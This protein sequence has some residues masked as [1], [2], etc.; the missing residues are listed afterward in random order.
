MGVSET[1]AIV[2][3]TYKLAEADKITVFLS[4][5]SGVMRGVARGARRLKSKFG[6]ALEPFTLISLSYFEKEGQ[7]LVAIRQ[8]EILRSYFE[9]SKNTEIVVALEYIGG[10]ILEFTPPHEPNEKIFR[11]IRAC[12]EAIATAPENIRHVTRYCEVW[13]LKLAGFLPDLR[14]C[15]NCKKPL[16]E[17]REK[18]YLGTDGALRCDKCAYKLDLLISYEAIT[19]LR[20]TQRLAPG[21][22]ARSVGVAS[23]TVLKELSQVTQR[24]ITRALERLPRGRSTVE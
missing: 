7:E 3:R 8:A 9:L 2:L 4:Q 6:A 18:V 12:V 1:E 14:A 15:V 16:G 23:E 5:N 11:M 13:L 22:W 17:N 20:T 24:L 10:L 19:H 21:E